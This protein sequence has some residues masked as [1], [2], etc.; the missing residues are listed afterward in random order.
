MQI[1]CPVTTSFSSAPHLHRRPHSTTTL[2]DLQTRRQQTW[3]LIVAGMCWVL[4][5]WVSLWLARP[6]TQPLLLLQ[7]GRGVLYISHECQSTRRH[8]H[9][10]QQREWLLHAPTLPPPLTCTPVPPPLPLPAPPLPPG[11]VLY[12]HCDLHPAILYLLVTYWVEV[13][14]ETETRPQC[15]CHC[16][17]HSFW[18]I[19]LS[20]ECSVGANGDFEHFRNKNSTPM[21]ASDWQAMTS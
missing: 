9:D 20:A 12:T 16:Q 8:H 4:M 2:V 3:S 11:S 18:D 7:L 15:T 5:Y 1:H 13:K 19:E 21:G 6:V 17:L 10:Q 14:H